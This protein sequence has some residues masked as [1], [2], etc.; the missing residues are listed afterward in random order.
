M[1][2]N[3][4]AHTRPT[5]LDRCREIT[6]FASVHLLSPWSSLI[7]RLCGVSFHRRKHRVT[8]RS[9]GMTLHMIHCFICMYKQ[10]VNLIK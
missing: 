10:R 2:A 1:A 3:I 5:Y 7:C 8:K 6:L 4:Y 9:A